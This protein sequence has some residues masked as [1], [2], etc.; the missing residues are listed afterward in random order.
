MMAMTPP[1]YGRMC[2]DRL[3]HDPYSS[4]QGPRANHPLDIIKTCMTKKEFEKLHFHSQEILQREA[5][6]LYR[7]GLPMGE[8]AHRIRGV[9]RSVMENDELERKRERANRRAAAG[10]PTAGPPPSKLH[11]HEVIASEQAHRDLCRNGKTPNRQMSATQHVIMKQEAERVLERQVA[12]RVEQ[13]MDL[14][15]QQMMEAQ[16]LST[17][18]SVYP[19]VESKPKQQRKPLPFYEKLQAGVDE[20]LSGVL[21]QPA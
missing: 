9:I 16:G 3:D 7:H 17:S 19:K 5:E 2:D 13:Q 6:E 21:P 20:W 1:N 11:A 8:A 4:H 14:I 10:A 18:P 15:T 12:Q